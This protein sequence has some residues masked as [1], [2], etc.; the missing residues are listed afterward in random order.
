MPKPRRGAGGPQRRC[1][2][3]WLVRELCRSARGGPVRAARPP[4]RGPR[5]FTAAGALPGVGGARLQ[6]AG[7]CRFP[8]GACGVARPLCRRPWAIFLASGLPFPGPAAL[9]PPRPGETVAG[10]Q[11]CALAPCCCP[12][13]G[14]CVRVSVSVSLSRVRFLGLA[15]GG[16]GGGR[17]G[18]LGTMLSCFSKW[19]YPIGLLTGAC[20]PGGCGKVFGGAFLFVFSRS[21]YSIF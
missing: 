12:R 1:G 17:G 4:A 11:L 5:A 8:R 16:A 2:G 20:R 18:G 21:T 19:L 14:V 3:W 10:G 13:R 9:R 6:R 7:G 15:L